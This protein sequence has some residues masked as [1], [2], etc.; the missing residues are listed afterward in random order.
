MTRAPRSA[1]SRVQK[2]PASTRVKSST[3]TPARS[4]RSDTPAML[5]LRRGLG[6]ETDQVA[7]MVTV[8]TGRV[9]G[10]GQRGVAAREE[11]DELLRVAA[12]GVDGR[13]SALLEALH[14][15]A[16]GLGGHPRLVLVGG[17]GHGEDS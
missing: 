3:V 8:Q 12:G 15:P 13:A 14:V 6:V 16:N 1:M 2:G 5:L 17:S 9:V 11:L 7:G 4:E 10:G